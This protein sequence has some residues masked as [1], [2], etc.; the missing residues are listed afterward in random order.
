MLASATALAYHTHM[1]LTVLGSGTTVPHPTRTSSGYWLETSSGTLLLDCSAGVQFRIAAKGLDWAN[2][3][4]IW[5]SH[6]H[7]DHVGG[8][9]PYLQSLKVA[10]ECKSREAPLRIFGPVGLQA[11][12]DRMNAVNDYRLLEQPFP[13]GIFEQASVEPFFVLPGVEALAVKTPHTDESQALFI[14][15]SN[16]EKVVYSSDTGPTEILATLGNNADLFILECSYFRD[17]GTDKHLEL[18]EAM[19]I[20]RKAHPKRAMLTHFYAEWDGVN[21]DEEVARFDPP[22]EVV[23]AVDGLVINV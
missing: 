20:I 12:F 3:D 17:K 14:R 9:A 16:G 8:L 4:A 22:C 11:W 7:L 19:H 2:V 1:K 13:I 18:A 5:I 21:F 15:D 10:P 6:F 23:E